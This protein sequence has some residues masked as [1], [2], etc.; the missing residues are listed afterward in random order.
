MNP[1]TKCLKSIQVV[2][3]NSK[4][5]NLLL[6]TVYLLKIP[7]KTVKLQHPELLQNIKYNINRLQ[8]IKMIKLIHLTELRMLTKHKHTFIPE[9]IRS[10]HQMFSVILPVNSLKSQSLSLSTKKTNY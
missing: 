5:L 2:E 3:Q 6:K 8:L 10:K 7:Q 9:H 1:K 4:W